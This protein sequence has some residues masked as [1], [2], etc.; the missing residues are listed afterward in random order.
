[1]VRL[2]RAKSP[3]EITSLKTL[4]SVKDEYL[5]LAEQYNSI[6]N[7]EIILC[8]RCGEWRLRKEFFPIPTNETGYFPVCKQCMKFQSAQMENKMIVRMRPKNHL[9]MHCDLLIYLS[10]ETYMNKFA[11]NLTLKNSRRWEVL[12][13]S[14]K[15]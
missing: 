5:K 8:N 12:L 7:N 11:E 6:I 14:R 1:M 15:R 10:I 4:K 13:L 9:R 3:T 2:S